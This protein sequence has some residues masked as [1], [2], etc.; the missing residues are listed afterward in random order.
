M[1]LVVAATTLASAILGYG[2]LY[3][4]GI[5]PCVYY[6]WGPGRPLYFL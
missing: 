1:L 6:S 4:T 5:V 2:A 3:P